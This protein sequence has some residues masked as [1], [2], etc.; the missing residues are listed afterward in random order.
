M[1]NIT[2]KVIGMEFE[3]D[4]IIELKRNLILS[5]TQKKKTI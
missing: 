3:K 2:R 1:S 5:L 4:Q